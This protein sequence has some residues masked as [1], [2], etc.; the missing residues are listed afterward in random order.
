MDVAA[1]WGSDCHAVIVARSAVSVE[2]AVG[3]SNLCSMGIM[4]SWRLAC[5]DVIGVFE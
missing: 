1:G 3:N 2:A 4:F 5:G